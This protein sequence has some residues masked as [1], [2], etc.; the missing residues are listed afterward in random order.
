MASRRIQDCHPILENAW[1]LAKKEWDKLHPEKPEPFLTC[2]Y[3]PND[4]QNALYD[5]GRKNKNPKKTNAQAGQSPHNFEPS[6]AFDIAF[7]PHGITKQLDW[8]PSL[9]ADFFQIISKI[10][11]KVEWGGSWKK[12]KDRPHYQLKDWKTYIK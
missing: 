8:T 5:E 11:P 4:E 12:F 3:R 1:Q 2:T 10:E 6:L 9:F 7:L